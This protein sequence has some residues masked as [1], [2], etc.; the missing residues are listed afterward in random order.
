M[1][2]QRGMNAPKS[3]SAGTAARAAATVLTECLRRKRCL[4]PYSTKPSLLPS[5]DRGFAC[6][7]ANDD[8]PLRSG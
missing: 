6:A 8:A 4:M 1:R 5:R 2:D 7:I 3:D